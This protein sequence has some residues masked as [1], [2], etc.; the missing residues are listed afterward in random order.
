MPTPNTELETVFEQ[1]R[2]SSPRHLLE[3]LSRIGTTLAKHDRLRPEIELH[4]VG[5]QS[6]RG[7]IISVAD[8]GGGAIALVHT[9]GVARVPSVAFV[10][11]EHI[12]AITLVDASVLAKPVMSDAPIPSKLELQR[13]AAALADSL[14]TTLARSISLELGGAS[15][16]DDEGR[17]AI[18]LLLPLAIEVISA[19]AGDAMGREA[20]GRI[21]ALELGASTEGEV[22]LDGRRLNL[23]AAKLLSAQ[24]THAALRTAIEKLL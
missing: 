10:R 19:I 9:G 18:G 17:R 11:V 21:D 2:P 14:S 24:P 6:V 15:E 1:L 8:H 13:Q 23:R 3:D 5:G 7:R 20:L 16:L 4:L 12:A 22:K